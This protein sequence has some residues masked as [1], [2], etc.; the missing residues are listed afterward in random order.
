MP[1][2]AENK[3]AATGGQARGELGAAPHSW[4]IYLWLVTVPI[5]WGF[6]FICLKILYRPEVGFTVPG[7]L[8]V[9]YII[10]F[11][12]LGLCLLFLEK[13]W[14]IDREDWKY[15]LIFAIITVGIYQYLFAKAIELTSASESALLISTA[16]IWAFLISLAIGLEKFDSRRLAGVLVGF[17]GIGLVIY[18]GAGGQNI[19]QTHILGDGVMI[20]AAIL[21][22]AYAVFSPPLLKKY[23]PMKIVAWVHILGAVMLIPIGF[24]DM[25][26]VDLL[27]LGLVPWVCILQY[28]VLAG[29]YA[30]IIWY[31]GVQ[32]IGAAQT[33]LFQY[34]VPP[35]ALAAAYLILHEVPTWMQML[36][37][38]V[39]LIG[40]HL[41][42]KRNS[43]TR[44]PG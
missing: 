23:S 43:I 14:R 41:A 2:S 20:I 34:L 24:G 10:M 25:M 21:W 13:D 36:G 3:K 5:I 29:V 4:S 42:R 35:L 27:H 44:R 15:L 9:R 39:T 28:S 1:S 40:I 31:Q 11:V 12:G 8:S 18:G 38:G 33:M 6:N 37:M 7:M 16:P 19:P 32:K 22:A 30:F 26:K 17:L